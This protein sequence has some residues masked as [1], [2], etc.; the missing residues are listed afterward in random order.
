MRQPRFF[1][2]FEIRSW[3]CP[4]GYNKRDLGKIRSPNLG[5]NSV[6][7]IL[8]VIRILVIGILVVRVLVIGI[9]VI[10]ILVIGILVVR[11]LVVRVLV[12]GILVVRILVVRVLVVGILVIG[13]LVVRVLVIGIFAIKHFFSLL[14]R[15]KCLRFYRFLFKNPVNFNPKSHLLT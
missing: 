5:L 11:V 9:L 10:G 6:L 3:R 13:I 15:S 4:V 12:I 1:R 7:G 8:V 2:F 14:S